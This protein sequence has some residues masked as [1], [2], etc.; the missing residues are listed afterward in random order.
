MQFLLRCDEEM[1]ELTDHKKEV[2][3]LVIY[4]EITAKFYMVSNWPQCMLSLLFVSRV[5]L[6]SG[7]V[8]AALKCNSWPSRF[9]EE[10]VCVSK[11]VVKSSCVNRSLWNISTWHYT[12]HLVPV[13]VPRPQMCIIHSSSPG[14]CMQLQVGLISCAAVTRGKKP[15]PLL[16]EYIESR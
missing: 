11:S 13:P 16:V 12:S 3:V 5:A 2:T 8:F 4:W 9:S 1:W 6:C 15:L 7:H 10:L 14:L